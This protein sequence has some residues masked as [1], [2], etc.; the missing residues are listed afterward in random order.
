MPAPPRR[1]L[2]RRLVIGV[3]ASIN[4]NRSTFAAN[5]REFKSDLECANCYPIAQCT[6]AEIEP[7]K[8]FQI[9]HCLDRV[10]RVVALCWWHHIA[11]IVWDSIVIII[12]PKPEGLVLEVVVGISFEND[13]AVA[14]GIDR[15]GDRDEIEKERQSIDIGRLP[16]ERGVYSIP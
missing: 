10:V 3:G 12:H 4:I 2:N 13:I 11:L 5:I 15:D 16:G 8:V 14:V 9:A 7:G 1:R 6:D